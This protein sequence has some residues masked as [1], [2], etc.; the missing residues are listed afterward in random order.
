MQE[1]KISF[2]QTVGN[3]ELEV[4]AKSLE[5]EHEQRRKN[6]RKTEKKSLA[7]IIGTP[8]TAYGKCSSNVRF[9]SRPVSESPGYPIMTT[10][11]WL[12]C[13]AVV[14]LRGFGFCLPVPFR[15]PVIPCPF[16]AQCL[17][18][19][20]T[21]NVTSVWGACSWSHPDGGVGKFAP[22]FTAELYRV[23]EIPPEI[24]ECFLFLAA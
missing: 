24:P 1:K 14:C 2:Q 16:P 8:G 10:P 13:F 9:F 6:S 12:L 19:R 5:E 21:N 11:L 23:C 4:K 15:C 7:D 3:R 20:L 22:Q 17:S 18:H